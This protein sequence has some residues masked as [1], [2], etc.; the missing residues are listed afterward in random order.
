M[1]PSGYT[2]ERAAPHEAAVRELVALLA[3]RKIRADVLP[4][5]GHNP[6]L[7]IDELAVF[8]DVKTSNHHENLAIEVECFRA[9]DKLERA[10]KDVLVVHR[11]KFGRW[12]VDCPRSLLAR[13][14]SVRPATANGSNDRWYLIA[15]EIQQAPA[16][17]FDTWF[18]SES[19]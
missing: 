8:V 15:L 2:L 6:D 4:L 1:R 3:A 7:W 9:W 13:I 5:D 19:G 17:S 18:G 12:R 11:D 10:G 14:R 16:T